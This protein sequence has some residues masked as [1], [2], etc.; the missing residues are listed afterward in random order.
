MH[1]YGLQT[2]YQK[3]L[4]GVVADNFMNMSVYYSVVSKEITKKEKGKKWKIK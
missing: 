2:V 3:E 4:L 1:T